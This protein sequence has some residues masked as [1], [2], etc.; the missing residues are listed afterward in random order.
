MAESRPLSPTGPSDP[1]ADWS[2]S[3]TLEALRLRARVLRDIRAFFQERGVLEVETPLLSAAAAQDLHLHS[4]QV[5]APRTARRGRAEAAGWLHTSPEYAM[6]RLLAAGSGPIYQLC[7]VFRAGERGGLHNPE[8]TMLEWYRPGLSLHGL[9]DEVE[10]LLGVVVDCPPAEQLPYAQAFEAAVGVD[11]HRASPAE[12]RERARAL[13]LGLPRGGRLARD[14]LLDLLFSHCVAPSLGRDGPCFVTDWPA[15]QAALAR[16]R[17]GDP[18]VA[19][20]FELFVEGVEFANGYR[21]LIDPEEHCLRLEA[22][23][24]LR[25]RAGLPAVALDERLLAAVRHGLPECSGV[26]LG[27]DRLV[28]RAAGA[29]RIDQVLAFASDRA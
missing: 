9:M 19:E 24:A 23:R 10:A 22:Q 25:R 21:E 8:F 14:G 11:P 18:P 27:V 26:A 16:V 15:S 20:R 1:G 5:T 12:L 7:K 13:G 28:M 3:A 6:K 2:P 17:P 29:E 4:L